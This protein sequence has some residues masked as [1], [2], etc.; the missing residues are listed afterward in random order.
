M[1]L[2]RRAPFNADLHVLYVSRPRTSRDPV[3]LDH[4]FQGYVLVTSDDF[5]NGLPPDIRATLE[6]I[7]KEVSVEVNRIAKSG[8]ANARQKVLQTGKVK[9][10]EVTDAEMKVWRETLRP[11]RQQFEGEIGKALLEAADAANRGG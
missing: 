5:W 11:I 2:K 10:T 3:H 8:Q 9:V 6:E 1:A 4:T 7:L